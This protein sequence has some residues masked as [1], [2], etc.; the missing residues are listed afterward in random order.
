MSARRVLLYLILLGLLARVVYLGQVAAL[1]FF[2]DPVGD[3]ARYLERAEGILA[4][5]P[6]GDRAFFYGGIFY[7]WLLALDLAA[8]GRNFYPVCLLQALSG[9]LLAWVL[10]ALVLRGAAPTGGGE[11]RAA[12]LVAAGLGLFYGPFAFLEAD[13]LM[14]CWTLLLEM[15]AALLLLKAASPSTPG[16]PWRSAGPAALAGVLVGLAASERP[17]LVALLP[18]LAVWAAASL[19]AGRRLRGATSLLAGGV[20]VVLGVSAMNHA[21]SGRW[22]PLT[23]SGGINF[24]I[25]NNPSA[26]GTFDEPWS[27]ADLRF[28]ARYT[29]LEESS[30]IMAR[31]LAGEDLDPIEASSFWW[32]RGLE[33]LREHP[34]DAARLWGRKLLLFWNAVEIPNHLHFSFMRSTAPALRLLPVTFILVGPFGLYGFLSSR[35]RRL[36]SGRTWALLAA[37]VLVPMITVLPFFV[38]DRYRIVA[39]P[40]LIVAAACGM[41]SIARDLYQRTRLRL[42]LPG[43]GILAVA[44]LV[45][46]LPLTSFD[47]ARDHW[48]LAQAWK[49][50]GNLPEAVTQYERALDEDPDDAAIRNNLGVALASLDRFAEAESAYLR[51]IHDGPGLAYP[52]KN[53]GLLLLAQGRHDEAFRWLREA[54]ELEPDD[55]G[56]ERGLAVLFMARGDREEAAAR[57]RKVLAVAPGDRTAQRVIEAAGEDPPF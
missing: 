33:Y 22:V 28:T 40:P 31:R 25:G 7:P 57:A 14:I 24:Y 5:H 44:F 11:V 27:G 49:K 36:L 29:D 26:R 4:G 47:G 2:N 46:V 17:N 15:S 21:A 23:T 35:S 16:S 13:L 41:T 6:V 32:R 20:A 50:Q 43:L 30:L 39:V 56:T 12:A 53:L 8:F 1:P 9:C 3:S 45:A 51:A 34:L 54:E 10:H 18:V 38:A 37:L 19:P 52:R 55:P 48:L 42:L